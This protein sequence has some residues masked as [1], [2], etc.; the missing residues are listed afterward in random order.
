MPVGG[1]AGAL[2]AQVDRQQGVALSHH[3]NVRVGQRDLG[4]DHA[5]LQRVGAALDKAQLKG[6]K[7]SLIM[8]DGVA[9]V[10]NVA[11]RRIVTALPVA[12]SKERVFTN[13]DG[14]VFA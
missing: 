10:A 6:V 14:V 5:A 3:A 8:L 7:T 13:I 12:A 2:A 1:F 11:E 4:L 9:M